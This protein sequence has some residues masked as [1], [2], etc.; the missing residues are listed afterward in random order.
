MHLLEAG[1]PLSADLSGVPLPDSAG[2]HR[3]AKVVHGSGKDAP[4]LVPPGSAS[5]RC[6]SV[7][8][9]KYPI[10]PP[11]PLLSEEG[12]RVVDLLNLGLGVRQIGR[13]IGCTHRTIQLMRDNPAF[14]P[15][16][17]LVMNLEA[18]HENVI[19]GKNRW[20]RMVDALVTHGW[21]YEHIA[22]RA[23]LTEEYLR[24]QFNHPLRV[25]LNPVGL[26]I[27]GLYER[28]VYNLLRR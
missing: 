12:R 1:E 28:H 20:G 5:L 21:T 6:E 4:W 15:L 27:E 9:V 11:N 25:P 16:R 26:V 24:G 7:D 2:H 14:V 10:T 19:C 22:I 17:N 23:Q 18:L 13:H 8:R 3:R